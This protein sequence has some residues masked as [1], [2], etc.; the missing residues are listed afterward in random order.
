[1]RAIVSN[2]QVDYAHNDVANAAWF[3]KER[4]TKAF[5]AQDRSDGI[6]LDMMAMATMTAF[7][8]EGYVNFV[9]IKLIEREH[10]GDDAKDAWLRFEKKS[11]RDKIKIIRRLTGTTIDWNRRPYAHRPRLD[12]PA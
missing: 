10:E 3:F 6:F 11:P 1:M 8:L 12:G 9:G 2:H 4:L 7:A 5:Q